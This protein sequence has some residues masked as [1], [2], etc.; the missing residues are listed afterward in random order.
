MGLTYVHLNEIQDSC[1][2]LIGLKGHSLQ[3]GTRQGAK[4]GVISDACYKG[5]LYQT[6]A[7]PWF[8]CKF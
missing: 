2:N 1:S 6:D 8:L 3:G 5:A 7:S 4:R